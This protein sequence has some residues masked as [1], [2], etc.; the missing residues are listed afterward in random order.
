MARKNR[1]EQ[2]YDDGYSRGHHDGLKEGKEE[3]YA[4]GWRD[5]M[6]DTSPPPSLRPIAWAPAQPHWIDLI[7]GTNNG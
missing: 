7:A 2:G 4:K 5:S 3:G 6:T 1:Y